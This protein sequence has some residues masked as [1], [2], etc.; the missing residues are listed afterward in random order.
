VRDVLHAGALQAAA[1][2]LGAGGL[3]QGLV[4]VLAGGAGHERF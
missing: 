3:E 4:G 2:E 1:R